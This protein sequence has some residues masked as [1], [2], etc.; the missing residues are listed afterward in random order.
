VA[1]VVGLQP[2]ERVQHGHVQLRQEQRLQRE[3]VRRRQSGARRSQVPPRHV[4]VLLPRIH[5]LG[6]KYD[7]LV[8]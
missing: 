7:E 6:Q 8:A 4:R 2:H 1:Q 5:E 3:L